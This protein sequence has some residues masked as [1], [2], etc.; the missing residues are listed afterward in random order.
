MLSI[1]LYRY[2]SMWR[3]D[4]VYAIVTTSPRVTHV[5][6][7]ATWCPRAPCWWPLP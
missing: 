7:W 4:H 5:S 3:H 1:K 6:I 2:S